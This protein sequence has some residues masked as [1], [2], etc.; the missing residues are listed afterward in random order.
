[1]SKFKQ[2][3]HKSSHILK[4]RGL[5]DFV[6]AAY[7]RGWSL[8]NKKL[9][10][11][12]FIKNNNKAWREVK[13]IFIGK[14]VFLIGNGPSLNKTELYLLKDEYTICFNHFDLFF[15]RINWFPSFYSITDNLVLEDKLKTLSKITT[16]TRFSFFP[17]IHFK[18][19]IFKRKIK[20]KENVL[21]IDQVFGRGFSIKLPCIYQGG[22]VIYEA[23]QILVHLGFTEIHLLGVDMSYQIHKNVS[24]ISKKNKSD[25]QSNEDDDPNHFDPRY[26]GKGKNY[27]QPE[28]YIIQNILNNLERAAIY[29]KER[30]FKI[31]NSGYDSKVDYFERVPL[32]N[33]FKEA[34]I[35]SKFED[36]LMTLTEYSSVIEFQKKHKKLT[37]ETMEAE[38]YINQNFWIDIKIGLLFVKQLVL[39]HLV[40][41]PFNDNL[42]V[43]KRAEKIK[44]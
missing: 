36:L 27:H 6:F 1:M 37:K 34:E 4:S 40:L 24:Y 8:L 3:L 44:G 29:S 33:L 13:D 21:W 18:G 22:T 12:K 31:I 32:Q 17:H 23:M 2:I 35:E 14:R 39:S 19:T 20:S 5:R 41:G 43:I 25:I 9:L 11:R 26:F 28:G 15:D 42:Y 10:S 38:E 16:K 7:Y 30:A